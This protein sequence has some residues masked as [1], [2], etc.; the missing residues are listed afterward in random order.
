[1]R[2]RKVFDNEITSVHLWIR[3]FKDEA[4]LQSIRVKGDSQANICIMAKL[5]LIL[6]GLLVAMYFLYVRLLVVL[7]FCARWQ[8][9]L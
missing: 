1:M 9:T 6:S 5:P 4:F 8:L 3:S 7:F 2:N